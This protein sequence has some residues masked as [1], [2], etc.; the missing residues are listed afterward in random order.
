MGLSM[1]SRRSPTSPIDAKLPEIDGVLTR[2]N[3]PLGGLY[4]RMLA[5]TARPTSH[6]VLTVDAY[7][8]ILN[9]Q[10]DQLRTEH[11]QKLVRDGHYHRGEFIAAHVAANKVRKAISAIIPPTPS[12]QSTP[13]VDE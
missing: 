2:V 7:H 10:L 6:R 12:H 8:A 13:A 9:Q 3:G 11:A 5:C 4:H 1:K